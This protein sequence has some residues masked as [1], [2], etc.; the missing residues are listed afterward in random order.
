MYSVNA[1]P[2]ID[3]DDADGSLGAGTTIRSFDRPD[4]VFPPVGSRVNTYVRLNGDPA[5]S[6]RGSGGRNLGAATP[7]RVGFWYPA[8][9]PRRS[10]NL[11]GFLRNTRSQGR[12]CE[13]AARLRRGCGNGIVSTTAIR[14]D[15]R[16]PLARR[17][18]NLALKFATHSYDVAPF[19][20]PRIARW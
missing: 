3:A 10:A 1:S 17:F 19:D 13:Q 5:L 7:P 4:P 11:V 14:I 6:R 20:I 12:L 9:H 2:D 15:A 18:P 16:L 8:D